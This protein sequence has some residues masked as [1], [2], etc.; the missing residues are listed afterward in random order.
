MVNQYVDGSL[1]NA[2]APQRF[3]IFYHGGTLATKLWAKP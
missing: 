3:D 2:K 1:T